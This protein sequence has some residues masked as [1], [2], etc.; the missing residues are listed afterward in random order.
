MVAP[1]YLQ[2]MKSV[3]HLGKSIPHSR[4]LLCLMRCSF[5]AKQRPQ[6]SHYGAVSRNLRTNGL[7][8]C[9]Y[10]LVRQVPRLVFRRDHCI[11][12]V[13]HVIHM[14]RIVPGVRES[15]VL[16]RRF[17]RWRGGGGTSEI[18]GS[19][20]SAAASSSLGYLTDDQL[21]GCRNVG[22]YFT[23]IRILAFYNNNS[24]ICR[25]VI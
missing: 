9:Y 16:F 20:L 8:E 12:V 1:W 2:G 7:S 6:I 24:L 19:A 23:R 4:V 25:L 15:G 22:S 5:R 21:V 13:I 14:V 3:R 18:Y 17:L 11:T 10:R